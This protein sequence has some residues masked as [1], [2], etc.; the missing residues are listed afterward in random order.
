[1]PT[2]IYKD[3][4]GKRIPSVTTVLKELGWSSGGLM[5]WAHSI[6]LQGLDLND[7]RQKLADAGTVGHGMA[8]CDI[9]G[10]D[11]ETALK[12][13]DPETAEKAKASFASYLSW[14]RMSRLEL[15]ASEVAL[16]SQKLRTGGTL[17]AVAVFDGAAGL[18]DFKSSKDLYPDTICQVAAYWRLWEENNPDMPL[19]H[20]HVFRWAPDGGFNHHSLS[21]AQVEAGWEVFQHCRAI[22]D[23]RKRVKA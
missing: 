14:R 2:Q 13:V 8:S 23:L 17:D 7:A 4:D 10:K 12:D 18:L 21:R 20:W 11:P 22:Y 16:V 15:V 5:F 1:M 6:G 9:T 3:S 19:S